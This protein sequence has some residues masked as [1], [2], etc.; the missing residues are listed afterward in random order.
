MSR[1]IARAWPLALT[2]SV[3]ALAL[4]PSLA[5]AETVQAVVQISYDSVGRV[6]C[7]A[8]RM[9]PATFA[10]LPASACTLGAE[11]TQGKDRVTKNVYD[12]AGRPIQTRKAVGTSFEQAYVTN[13]YTAN[14][15]LEYVID[16]NGNRAKLEYDGFDRRVKWVFPSATLPASFNPITPAT[17]LITAGSLNTSDY[18]QYGFDANGNRTSLRKRDGSVS[19]Y[20]Y[21]N[22]N[23]V[24]TKVVPERSGLAI[25]HTRDVYF[26]YD[27]TGLMTGARFDSASGEGVTSGFD[28]LGRLSSSTLAMDSTSRAFTYQYDPQGNRT[29]VTHPDANYVTYTYD[30]MSRPTAIQRSG[31][32]TVAS[33]AY[34]AIGQRT[35][36][37]GGISTSYG[38]DAIGRLSS[39]TNNLPA[40]TYNNQWTFSYNPASQIT[41]TT[42]SNDQFAWTANVDVVRPYQANGLNQYTAAGSAA[43]CY[44]ANGNL[45]ADGSS[46]YLYDVENRLV[47]RRAQGAGNTN[48]LALSYAGASQAGLRYDPMGRLYEV[49]GAS[50]TTRMLYD[51]DALT[52]EY[53]TSGTLLRRYVHG[54]DM[55][56][57]DPIAWYEGAAFT[58]TSERMMRPNWQ[59]S[60]VLVTDTTGGTVLAANSYD[61][62][63]I[64][65]AI[66]AGRFQYTGQIWL[67]ELGMYYYKARIYSPTLGRFLQTDP[68]G[69]ED[70][71]NLYTYSRNDPINR[72]DFNGMQSDVITVTGSK[73][74]PVSII[75][76]LA[77][78]FG[79]PSSPITII[80]S[81]VSSTSAGG[82]GDSC[83]NCSRVTTPDQNPDEF[84]S[85]KGSSAKR[86]KR[87]GSIWEPDRSGGG[88]GNR[89][90]E[91]RQWKVWDSLK[92]W[93]RRDK[94][95]AT[96]RADGRERK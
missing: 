20:G 5:R 28:G 18:E 66:N 19:T 81:L 3:F 52:G 35:A 6:E 72:T 59:G 10:T 71:K 80:S 84:E 60:I 87:N 55:K 56:A 40:S 13:S 70:E 49:S 88:H 38:Y 44:D 30:A 61:E 24:T 74:P 89:P 8:E 34:N 79:I 65:Q 22:L 75:G 64:P 48:C 15:A 29:R 17:A 43:F 26:S 62:Y 76:I 63:G 57:D 32:A 45:T 16:A 33:Y 86:N 37:N 83:E 12:Q 85:I 96:I 67:P 7:T 27:L 53:N 11:G 50:G 4:A 41:Q 42:R 92:A 82:Y 39:L 23:R 68:I 90:G 94:P 1:T 91:G 78:I 31:T 69:Y 95:V 77:R 93:Q 9:N 21:D 25:T 2:S 14:G 46:V 73:S 54:A 51:G 58:A 36:F 47:E